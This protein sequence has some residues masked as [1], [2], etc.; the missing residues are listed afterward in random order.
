[1]TNSDKCKD[2]LD[3]MKYRRFW[4]RDHSTGKDVVC[5]NFR[6]LQTRDSLQAESNAVDDF[7]AFLVSRG[8]DAYR[9]HGPTGAIFVAINVTSK[10]ILESLK[11]VES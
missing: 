5:V 11:K 7:V 4:H 6:E 8:V 9:H 1:M 3:R 2:A 10:N